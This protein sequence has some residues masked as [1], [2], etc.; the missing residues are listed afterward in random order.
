MATT[1]QQL[2]DFVI[3]RNSNGAELTAAEAAQFT[4]DFD[5]ELAGASVTVE[6]AKPGAVILGYLIKLF[7]SMNVP[8]DVFIF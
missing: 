4:A 5:A 6:G 1:Y 7:N 2:L 8:D 3:S